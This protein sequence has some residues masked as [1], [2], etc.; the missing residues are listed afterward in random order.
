MGRETVVEIQNKC[1]ELIK[2]KKSCHNENGEWY[3]KE[4]GSMASTYMCIHFHQVHL[5][6]HK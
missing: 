4:H 2:N 6:T 1:K 5:H 3:L